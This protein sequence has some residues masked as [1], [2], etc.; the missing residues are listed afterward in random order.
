M[1]ATEALRQIKAI[2]DQVHLGTPSTPSAPAP[3]PLG[4]SGS[5]K[6]IFND[7]F[8]GSAVD[9]TKWRL[10]PI[11]AA[12]GG[13]HGYNL[14][15]KGWYDPAH[16]FIRDGNLVLQAEKV[17]GKENLPYT[18][19]TVTTAPDKFGV[20]KKDWKY[21]PATFEFT[22]G[23]VEARVKLPKGKGLWPAFWMLRSD[24]VWPPEID[25]FEVVDPSCRKVAQH[26]H[27]GP[28]GQDHDFPSGNMP[29][30]NQGFDTGVD[31]S[32]DFH[33][34]GAE[35]SPDFIKWYIDGKVTQ[36]YGDKADIPNKPMYL[37]LNLAVGGQWPGDP[38]AS[39]KFPAEML[40]DRV[41]VFQKA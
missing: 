39:T 20:V 7:D 18:T 11:W 19:G 24:E 34:F 37:L 15:E 17:T 23:F 38:D 27:F 29:G 16:A 26:F 3:I 6:L 35:W 32:A 28:Q 30:T 22:Y 21:A 12:A 33:T 40:I 25:I 4:A 14:S 8:N 36:T 13:A 9:Q 31:L 10:G 41:S 2:L 1:E 5:W